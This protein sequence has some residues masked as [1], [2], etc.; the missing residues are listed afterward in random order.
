MSRKTAAAAIHLRWRFS[1]MYASTPRRR[2]TH[3]AHSLRGNCKVVSIDSM[4][5][6]EPDM[7]HSSQVGCGREL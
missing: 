7:K 5:S 4:L 1:Q 6:A 3:S 2:A